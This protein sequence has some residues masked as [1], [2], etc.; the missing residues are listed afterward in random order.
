MIQD[1]LASVSDESRRYAA[2]ALERAAV[3]SESTMNEAQPPR[4]R[5]R[6]LHRDLTFQVVVGMAL[7]VAI[8]AL[9][10]SIGK[11]LK[12]LGDVFI[13]LIQMVVGLIIF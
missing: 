5:L 7:G 11:E 6:A 9:W 8:G 4:G 2:V 10:P 13:R 12:P 1:A 3:M